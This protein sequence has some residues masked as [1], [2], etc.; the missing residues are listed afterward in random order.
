MLNKNSINK[1]PIREKKIKDLC[2]SACARI[3]L[4][5][6]AF[7]IREVRDSACQLV[8]A[9]ISVTKYI[10]INEISTLLDYGSGFKE[11]ERESPKS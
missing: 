7:Q 5:R 3:D 9:Q 1:L 6:S 10:Q 2:V 8:E 11:M 4:H